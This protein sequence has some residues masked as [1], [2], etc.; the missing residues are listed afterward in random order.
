[1]VGRRVN[2]VALVLVVVGAGHE[3]KYLPERAVLQD[4]THLLVEEAIGGIVGRV[5]RQ[6]KPVEDDEIQMRQ[7]LDVEVFGDLRADGCTQR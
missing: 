7:I 2:F 5:K 6:V 3:Q 1:M 4:G